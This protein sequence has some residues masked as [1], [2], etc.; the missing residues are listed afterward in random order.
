MLKSFFRNAD[1]KQE[2]II[3]FMSMLELLKIGIF[4]LEEQS[5][6]SEDGVIYTS[7]DISVS[8]KDNADISSIA[9]I[10]KKE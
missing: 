6:T 1:S 7:S 10:L 9:E 2:L 4:V 8:L 5:E 3:M